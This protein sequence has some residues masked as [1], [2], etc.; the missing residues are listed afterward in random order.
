[1]QKILA[2][3]HL[4]EERALKKMDDLDKRIMELAGL[5][6]HCSQIMIILGQDLTETD[7]KELVKAM[8]GL[9]GGMFRGKN[10]G[11]LTGGVALLSTYVGKSED[12]EAQ[13]DLTEIMVTELVDWFE[14]EFGTVECKQLVSDKK[15]DRMAVCP[16]LI[17]KTF[18]KCIGILNEHDIDPYNTV[19]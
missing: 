15:E 13:D 9:G 14:G 17:K 2:I 11:T 5:G 16:N 10:C 18:L 8:T 7:N 3:F 12:V 4:L 1:M 6:Y 19:R